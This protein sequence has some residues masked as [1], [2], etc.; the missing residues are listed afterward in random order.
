MKKILY[1][2]LFIVLSAYADER[3]PT[4]GLVLSG[5]GAR[6]G[7]HVGIL[8]YLEKR[9]IPV[10]YIVGTSMG[11][12]MGG[13]YA[14]GYSAEELEEFLTKTPWEK[15]V[16]SKKPRREISFRRKTLAAEFPGNIKVG[17]DGND[18]VALPT[19]VFEK[20]MMLYLLRKKLKNVLFIKDFRKLPIPYAAV[21]TR[22]V[23][24]ETVELV[25]GNIA[26][27]I[28]ASICVPGGFE[29]IEIEGELLVDGGI[30]KNLPLETMRK[31]FK[32]DYI[33][34]VDISTPFDKEKKFNSYDEI[35]SQ[36]LDILTR[37]N[38]EDTIKGMQPNEILIQPKLEG[39]S[40]LDADKYAEIIDIGYKAAEENFDKYAFLQVDT[41]TYEHYK[42][43]HRYKPVTLIP[44]IDKIEIENHTFISDE[45]I[46][47]RIH[48]RVG[49]ALDFEGLQKD[50]MHIYY[51]MIFSSVDY[52]VVC[53]EG[54]YV[55]I[56]VTKPS[57]NA[58]GDIRL[59]IEFEGDF[60]GH[61]DYQ[62]RLE[63]NKYDLNSYGGEWRN[64]VEVGKRRLVKTEIYQPLDSTQR[65]FVRINGYFEKVKH[66]VTPQFLFNTN[67]FVPTS[68]N[69]TLPLYSQNY[70]GVLGVGLTM[71]PCA[72]IEIGT[73]LKKVSPS[74][75]LFVY[76]PATDSTQYVT[77]ESS[78]YLTQAYALYR[79]DSLDNP[80]FPKYGY[81]GIVGYYKNL[82]ALHSDVEYS[83]FYM[84]FAGAFT[85]GRGTLVPLI[86]YGTTLN[87]GGLD[88]VGTDENGEAVTVL[89]VDAY[90]QLG[91]LFNISGRPTYY[92]S[93]DELV[94]GSLNYRYS[95][96]S[97]KFL[98]SITSEAYIGFSVETGKTWYKSSDTFSNSKTLFGS[99]IYLAIDTI[100]GPLY[101]AYGY[102][103]SSNQTVYFSLGKSY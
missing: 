20:Q 78:Q 17:I 69:K 1:I 90:F 13:L 29:P 89:D 49:E 95:V 64:R 82:K 26:K 32:P 58:H 18:D 44:I 74:V 41:K 21:A 19:G 5:G 99:S 42:Q 66:Y 39:Y 80:F 61:S 102:S 23:D 2:F 31:I 55:L 12:L 36:Q 50:L 98:S 94:F 30:S 37:K 43:K 73:Q 9:N 93:G 59:G 24:G 91:G 40:F 101:V 52:K 27:S 87:S 76:D 70:G 75:D 68:E 22:L 16:T 7:A 54:E 46:R 86:K 96:L 83:Q 4:V 25:E 34:V 3:R 88:N 72:Q 67:Q 48:Q 35:M 60:N 81:K 97:N 15:Y 71:G 53:K 85:I 65:S 56:I 63:Y 92:K 62:V 38:V 100:I 11:S 57:W 79:L 84:K 103:D 6:G 14:I 8:K 33:I 47:H 51:M 45:T 28:Y 77:F 10:D